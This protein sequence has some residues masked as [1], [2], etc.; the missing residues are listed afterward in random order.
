MIRLT[1]AQIEKKVEFFHHYVE[2]ENAAT[3]STLDA[4]ANVSS[5]NIA[6]YSAE[7]GKGEKVQLNRALICERLRTM[8]GQ[9]V[10]NQY[11]EDLESHLIYTH[12]ETSLM[13]YCVSI[14]MYPYLIHGLTQL[15]GESVAPKHLIA[16]C[17][18]FTNLIFAI[19]SQF[20]GAVASVEFLM[21]FDYFA[22]KDYGEDYL[23]KMP[24]F[25]DQMLQQVVFTMNEPAGA[26]GF[27][28][29]FWN[30]S[31]F[32]KDFFDEMFGKFVFP[33]GGTPNWETLDKLQKFYHSW[34][35]ENRE[36]A[37][38]TFPVVTH[39]S[40]TTE[41]AP[42]ATAEWK[43][44]DWFDF[45]AE[46]FSKGS[47]F[48]IYTSDTVDSL[49][50]C[51][52]LRNA[53]TTNEFSFSLGAG[54]VMTGS[55][56]VISINANR[57][58]QSEHELEDVVR[59]VHKYQTAFEAH[60]QYLFEKNMLP[61]YTAG[62]VT[63]EKQYLTIGINGLMESAE[64]L[65]YTPGY[66][67]DYMA[68]TAQFLGTIKKLNAEAKATYGGLWN[69][70]LVPA[71]SLGVKNAKWDSADGLWV[72]R[73]CYNSYLYPV[74][75]S[76]IDVFD[77]MRMHGV[78]NMRNLDGGSAFHD[79]Q[80]ELLSIDQYKT[81]LRSLARFGCN[82]YGHN[83]PRTQCKDCGYINPNNRKVCTKCGSDRVRYATRVIGYLKFVD[84][85]S[86]P[87]KDEHAK[88]V[89]RQKQPKIVPPLTC[90]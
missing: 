34:F 4:N 72:P 11:I 65:G 77:K 88:R 35:R 18:S 83:V 80:D 3:G 68:Y 90:G 78:E 38:L 67:E 63:L 82:Y 15:G 71:E 1:E 48:F 66:N 22:R 76:D 70:E 62:F 37:L 30:I 32:D 46:E 8:Y 69:T 17:G 60:Y 85:F 84:S 10:A 53:L 5:K 43:S 28:S 21:I 23:D 36:R 45:V 54:G 20:A 13:P 64:Y 26:R 58:T 59:R 44:Q 39:N 73:E 41:A 19:S 40:V 47:Q 86:R 49:S 87:R 61:V 16:F 6:T 9:D 51:C 42:S 79:N 57:L 50:S 2:A 12:D 31:T 29:C 89:Y 74:E 14:S 81:I 25:V 33:D 56:N 75:D 24:K 52:R 7:D 27:Q 55:K